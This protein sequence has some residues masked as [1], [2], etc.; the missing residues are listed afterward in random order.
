MPVETATY[1]NQLVNTNPVHTDGLNQGDAHIRLVKLTLQNTF[2]NFTAAALASSN[3][4]IDATTNLLTGV[5]GVAKFPLGT[6]GAPSVT[7]AGD[8]TTGMFSL[9][10][11][12][13]EFSISGVDVFGMNSTHVVSNIP[14]A[15]TSLSM[16]GTI[17]AS[18]AYSGG[19]GQLCP[20]GAIL[21]YHGGSAPTGWAWCNGQTVSAA[22]NPGLNAIYGNT[23]GN[24]TLP[25]WRCY[26]PVG[27][28]NMGSAGTTGRI[29]AS[30]VNASIGSMDAAIGQSTHILT[31]AE[32]PITNLTFT[33]NTINL[34][35]INLNQAFL[36]PSAGATVAGGSAGITNTTGSV[37]IPPFT[38]SGSISSFGG[39]GAHNIVQLGLTVGFIIKLG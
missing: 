34:G 15:G 1:I 29:A 39:G 28:D 31:N 23:G 30:G 14:I 19:T 32:L 3:S 17:S 37:T 11:G 2:P 33:G 12:D 36:Q 10:A 8:T 26:V 22:S 24:I 6:A 38:P 20:V 35:T 16:T 18:G 5:S 4:Q 21:M 13:I 9:G 7:F 25:D 27:V